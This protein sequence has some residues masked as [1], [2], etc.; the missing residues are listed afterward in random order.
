MQ[1]TATSFRS[2]A[3]QDIYLSDKGYGLA[4]SHDF[5]VLFNS[6]PTYGAFIALDEAQY[7]DYY[8][9]T[10]STDEE[11]IKKYNWIRS[12]NREAD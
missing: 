2:T 5:T 7:F 12:K 1:A 8:F 6:I 9:F 11:L 4:I 3:L 10:G